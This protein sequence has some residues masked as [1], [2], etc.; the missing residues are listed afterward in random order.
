MYMVHCPA[1]RHLPCTMYTAWLLIRLC[2]KKINACLLEYSHVAFLG[3]T[4]Q[5]K[6][7]TTCVFMLYT[8]NLYPRQH[9]CHCPCQSSSKSSCSLGIL[10]YPRLLDP[11]HLKRIWIGQE[12][13]MMPLAPLCEYPEP[14]FW[15]VAGRGNGFH[16]VPLVNSRAGRPGALK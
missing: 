1:I 15:K 12:Q 8:F 13:Y 16:Q 14:W 9:T 3:H 6:K 11:Q 5:W 2:D 10:L 7:P 4:W